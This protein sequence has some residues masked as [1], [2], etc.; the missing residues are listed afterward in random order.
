VK[1]QILRFL[2]GCSHPRTTFPLSRAGSR[3]PLAYVVCLDCGQEFDY[4]WR[5]MRIVPRA[6]AAV[7]REKVTA[8]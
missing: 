4:D 1:D 7:K 3:F 8:L 2:F 6:R 5:E